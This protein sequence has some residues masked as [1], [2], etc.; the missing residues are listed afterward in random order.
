MVRGESELASDVARGLKFRSTIHLTKVEAL[1]LGPASGLRGGRGGQAGMSMLPRISV[2]TPSF[3]QGR[4][5]ARTIDS[6]LA[7]GYANLEHIVVDGMS[8]DDTRA[9]L[10]RYPH[11]RVLREPDRGQSEAINK[12][13]RLATGDIHCFLNSDDTFLPGALHR[14]AREIDPGRGRHVV[15]GRCTHIDEEDRPLDVEH[16]SAYLG[17]RRILEVWK[18][19]TI[20][21]PATFWTREVWLSC[22]PLDELEQ[23]VPDYDL[24]CRFSQRYHFHFVD[25][26]LATYRLHDRSKTCTR[27]STDVMAESLRVSR[28]YW[29]SAWSIDR[30]RLWASLASH[31]L[32]QALQRKRWAAALTDRFDECRQRGDVFL[33]LAFLAGA[34]MCAP[35]LAFRRAVLDRVS[36]TLGR[37]RPPQRPTDLWRPDRT[38]PAT[39]AWRGFTGQH[40]NGCIGPTFVTPFH[41]TRAHTTLELELDT[42]TRQLP[43]PINVD[44]YVDERLVH[45]CRFLRPEPRLIGLPMSHLTPGCHELKIVSSTYMV[46][47]EFHGNGDYRPLS[48]RLNRLQMLPCLARAIRNDRQAA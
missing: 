29:P 11:L 44:V 12:G 25:Q 34:A 31:R 28:R 36:R 33:G 46:P 7:Q 8:T 41:A 5:I 42:V 6:V 38:A 17:H 15:M 39:L 40:N 3:N 1:A 43:W 4:F 21:Q 30:W 32:E 16:P 20:P 18:E 19:H 14:V 10:A 47:H 35:D 48:L 27:N 26:L 37:Y 23:A 9:V 13:F 22:G 45:Q 2:I 24:F